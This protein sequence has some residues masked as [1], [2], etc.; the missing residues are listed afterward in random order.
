MW[1]PGKR[2]I[3]VVTWPSTGKTYRRTVD[4]DTTI[5][6]RY[7][8]WIATEIPQVQLTR[9]QGIIWLDDR[10]LD[11]DK[12][13]EKSLHRMRTRVDFYLV[14]AFAFHQDALERFFRLG[15]GE[16]L[17]EYQLSCISSGPVPSME[18]EDIF[19]KA[20]LKGACLAEDF[21]Q[22]KHD[23]F[24][25]ELHRALTHR[26]STTL[27]GQQPT[28]LPPKM[29]R[30]FFRRGDSAAPFPMSLAQATI[31]AFPQHLQTH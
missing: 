17:V 20:H 18:D 19:R 13:T 22:E 24:Y 30:R 12:Y 6:L 28:I 4:Y 23:E 15:L 2:T 3:L 10:T 16:A 5:T 31:R 11:R 9:L 8:E 1:I 14:R 27:G 21:L 7:E 25:Y 26:F 29:P